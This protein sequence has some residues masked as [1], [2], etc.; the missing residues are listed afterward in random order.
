MSNKMQL[1]EQFVYTTTE[2]NHKKR[3]QVIIKSAGIDNNIIDLMHNQ[4]LMHT[5]PIITLS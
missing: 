1:C 2:I 3:Y 4:S 5:I